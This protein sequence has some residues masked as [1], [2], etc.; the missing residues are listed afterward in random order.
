[1]SVGVWHGLWA[2]KGTPKPVI[3]KLVASLNEGLKDAAFKERMG[4]LGAEI[5]PAERA[6]PKALAEHTKSEIA[7]WAPIIK[8][9]GQYAD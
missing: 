5:F 9:A 1:V 7:R 4:K 6:T 2:P 3:D 8:A